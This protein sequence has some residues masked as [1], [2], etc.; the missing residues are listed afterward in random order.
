MA[1]LKSRTREEET[2]AGGISNRMIALGIVGL[3]LVGV[4]GFLIWAGLGGGTTVST[5]GSYE[6]IATEGRFLGDPAA[7][8]LIREFSDF[9]CPHCRTASV[10]LLPSVIADYIATGKARLEVVPVAV[11]SQESEFAVEAA[12]CAAELGAFWPYHDLLFERQSRTTFNAANLTSMAEES[13]MDG[14]QFRNCLASGRYRSEVSAGSNAFRDA[15]A[16]GTPTFLVNEQV[17]RGAV[18]Y[19]EMRSVIEAELLTSQ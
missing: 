6:G 7:P 1:R 10:D 17:V 8:V 19:D 18:P 11:V 16:T 12:H 9:K 13:G 3:L 2:K 5:A 15:G 4:V 14:T